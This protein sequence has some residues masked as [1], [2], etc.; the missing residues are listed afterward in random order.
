MS[1]IENPQKLSTDKC[2]HQKLVIFLLVFKLGQFL[3]FN[4]KKL[5]CLW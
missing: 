4:K 2:K 3:K 1:I 5:G